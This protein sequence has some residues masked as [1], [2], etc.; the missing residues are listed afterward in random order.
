MTK[1]TVTYEGGRI[2]RLTCQGHAGS[3]QAGENTVCAAV[4][5][6]TQN[7]ANA[8]E[9]IAGITPETRV[10]E[11]KALIDIALPNAAG[12]AGH[13]AQIIL[14]TTLLGLTD[15]SQAYPAMVKLYTLNGRNIP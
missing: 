9:T 4:S 11:A 7:C 6:L 13:D 14:R 8:L 2:V 12:Q 15:I 10:D 3:A 5:I 1:V